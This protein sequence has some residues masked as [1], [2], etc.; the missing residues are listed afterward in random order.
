MQEYEDLKVLV[1]EIESDI[2]K[3]EGGNKAAGT[4]VRKQMQKI[5]QASQLVR[6]RILEI[7]SAD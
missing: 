5:K 3:A 1:A 7:R 2:N 4:R 6:N